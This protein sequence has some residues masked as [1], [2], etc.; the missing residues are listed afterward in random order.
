MNNKI[1]GYLK[2]GDLEMYSLGLTLLKEE[3]LSAWCALLNFSGYGLLTDIKSDLLD[4]LGKQ[5]SIGDKVKYKGMD[6]CPT[7]VVTF[8]DLKAGE[9]K[10][11]RQPMHTT[12]TVIPTYYAMITAKYWNSSNQTFSIVNDR[13][14]CF[15][16]LK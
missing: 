3:D 12:S 4:D 5:I 2:S 16:I 6:K 15:E 11:L 8:L 14:E 7:M 1:K 10:T 13:L 9:N